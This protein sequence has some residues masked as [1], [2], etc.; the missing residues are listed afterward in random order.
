MSK[1]CSIIIRTKNEE[2]WINSCLSAVYEQTYKNIEVII[3]DNNSS[4][5]TID[6]AKIF[7]R[8]KSPVLR[9]CFN[10]KVTILAEGQGK[11]NNHIVGEGESDYKNN[12]ISWLSPVAKCLLGKRVGDIV[13]LKKPNGEEEVEVLTIE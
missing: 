6:N 5:R 12:S 9:V 8:P 2:R 7:D 10:C 4:D 1:K 3:V 13:L 11:K